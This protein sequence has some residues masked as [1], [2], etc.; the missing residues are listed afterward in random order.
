MKV[1]CMQLVAPFSNLEVL[2]SNIDG[3]I[4]RVFV[5]PWIR[6]LLELV[7]K[8]ST[9]FEMLQ[10]ETTWSRT[11]LACIMFCKSGSKY[12]LSTKLPQR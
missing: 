9:F 3:I 12:G 4:F 11:V 5:F 10:L 1:Q 8:L 7:H 2:I 6:W